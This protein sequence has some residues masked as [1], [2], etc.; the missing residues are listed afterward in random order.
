LTDPLA[1]RR[2]LRHTFRSWPRP[3]PVYALLLG[4][5]TYDFLDNS[6]SHSVNYVPPYI[7]PEDNSAADENYV[8]FGDKQVLNSAGDQ[9][10]NPFPDMLIGRWPVKNAAQIQAVTA[11]ITR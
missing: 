10:A 11:K 8:Y 3:A 6:G 7:A 9:A 2:F 4:D 5:G 1:I